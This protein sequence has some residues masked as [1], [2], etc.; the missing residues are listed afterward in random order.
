MRQL[1]G[2]SREGGTAGCEDKRLCGG[3][4]REWTRYSCCLWALRFARLARLSGPSFLSCKLKRRS[5]ASKGQACGHGGATWMS[6]L[7]RESGHW[8]LENGARLEPDTIGRERVKAGSLQRF[9]QLWGKLLLR[10]R[11]A[12]H[13]SGARWRSSQPNGFLVTP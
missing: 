11:P 13:P 8:T 6:W 5:K 12:S 4:R 7:T 1:R 9:V 2:K 3:L 10:I